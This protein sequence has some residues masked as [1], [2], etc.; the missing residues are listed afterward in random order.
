MFVKKDLRK[1][2]QILEDPNDERTEIK[3]F[4][5]GPE[6]VNGP[7]FLFRPS[8]RLSAIPACKAATPTSA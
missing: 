8:V 5:R 1:V 4:R 7:G 3:L 2:Q 6:F